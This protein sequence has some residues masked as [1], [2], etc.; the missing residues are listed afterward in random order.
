MSDNETRTIT[1]MAS[2]DASRKRGRWSAWSRRT[3]MV[4]VGGTI[5]GVA[6]VAAAASY[7]IYYGAGH[8]ALPGTMIG[9]TSVSGMTR[10][11]ITQMISHA[12]KS[13]KLT[14]TGEGLNTKTA[15]LADL[16][17][18]VDANKTASQALAGNGSLSNYFSAPFVDTR[19][20][21]V[22]TWDDATLNAFASS[23]TE[24][25]DGAFPATEPSVHADEA[26]GKFVA[27][28]GKKG[29]GV[30]PSSLLKGAESVIGTDADYTLKTTLGD[31]EPMKTLDDANKLAEQANSLL[32]PAVTVSVGDST[33]T[34][35]VKQ[36]MSWV[37]VPAIGQEATT[38]TLNTDAVKQWVDAA[39]KPL[40]VTRVDGSRYVN[41]KGDVVLE[42]VKAVDGVN[43]AN[44]D[45][46][47]QGIVTSLSDGKAYTGAFETAV[48]KAEWKDTV[49]AAGAEKLAYPAAPGEKWIDIN[50]STR[51]TTAYEGATVVRGPVYMVPGAPETPTVTGRFAVERKVRSDTMRGFNADG[52]PYKT[53]N[54]PY[55]T[56]F[57]Q[58]YALHGAPWRSSFG[59]G[60]AGGSHGCINLPVGEAGWF[61]NWAPTG[62]V[63]VS[64]F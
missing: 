53:E 55:A 43:V 1:P 54:V 32:S 37:N 42:K 19:I 47:T 12:E 6:I 44:G 49:I 50:L 31:I 36:R 27:V 4:V 14:V 48:N 41:E 5:A 11:E 9:Q 57:Y 7:G 18:H 16:G 10:G 23:L 25:V 64:H 46:V 28:D 30:A 56:Y 20:R 24:G 52:T 33:A 2:G 59:P 45:A 29:H 15:S 38:A 8:R 40:L 26:A 62:T 34:P 35:D 3:K 61:Y 60:A 13:H 39:A 63:V 17:V 58:G 21:P 51:T 22:L